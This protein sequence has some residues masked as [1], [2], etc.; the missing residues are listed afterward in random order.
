MTAAERVALLQKIAEAEA[1]GMSLETA[2]KALSPVP[3]PTIKKWRKR[4]A[5]GGIKALEN[6]HSSGRPALADFLTDEHIGKIRELVLKTD[7]VSLAYDI[8]MDTAE[9]PPEV[10]EALAGRKSGGHVP[11]SLRRVASITPEVRALHRGEKGFGLKAFT[12]LRNDIEIMPDGSRRKI[13]PGD[14][15]ELDDMSMNQPFFYDTACL[16]CGANPKIDGEYKEP[17]PGCSKLAHRWGREVGRQS[18]WCIDVASAKWLGF[19]MI[20]RARDAYKAEDILRFL[21]KV[22]QTYGL[23]RRGLR[24]ERGIWMSKRI[25]GHELTADARGDSDYE[26]ALNGYELPAMAETE[27]KV[28]V[29][30]LA[31]LG[32]EVKYCYSPR[33][34]GMIESSFDHLQSIMNAMGDR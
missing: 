1:S 12:T 7:S 16:A 30:G 22:F 8:F 4:Y 23:P 20:G 13:I 32:L 2:C 25:K 15:F 33:T 5:E 6:D 29:G 19:D 28:I 27:K 18:L 10:S 17:G 26:D 34:K 24:L 3:L 31:D 21:R 11:M 9:C 14:W